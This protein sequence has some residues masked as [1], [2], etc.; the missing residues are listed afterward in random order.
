MANYPELE[1]QIVLVTGGGN[2]IGEAI[3]RAFHAQGAR[4]CFCDVDV[5]AG[6]ALM[7]ELGGEVFFKKVDLLKEREI[8]RW[9]EQIGNRW[10]QIHALV[11]N[12]AADTRIA[13]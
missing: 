2:G 11:N 13:F 7:K 3:V 12:A 1:S 10:K 6:Q 9:I 8:C 5:K 4:V